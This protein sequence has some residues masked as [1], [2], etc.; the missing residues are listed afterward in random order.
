M[1]NEDKG[2]ATLINPQPMF[3]ILAK[4]NAKE[5]SGDYV[6][7]M[8]IGDTPGFR[9]VQIEELLKKF[10]TTPHRY[11]PSR[12]ES[13]LINVLFKKE[14][15]EIDSRYNGISIAPANFLIM[16]SLAS[17]TSPGD[18]VLIPDPGFPT[19]ELVCK[20]LKLKIQRYSSLPT[21]GELRIS[22]L[23]FFS[24][25]KPKVIIINNP[26]N[27]IG[28]AYD[29]KSI[30]SFLNS[31]ANSEV[32]VIIDETYVNLVY[33]DVDAYIP[34]ID[35][36]RIRTF[37]KEYCAPGLRIG[38]CLASNIISQKISDFISLT[39]SCTP[40]FIQLAVAEYL[41][42][43]E[44][45][46]FNKEIKKEMIRRFKMLKEIMPTNSLLTNPNAGFYA[47]IKTGNAEKAFDFFLENN[48]ST[49]PGTRF[50]DTTKGA[51]RISIAGNSNNIEKDFILLKNAYMAWQNE[52]C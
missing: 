42:S 6:A 17:I 46:N 15:P 2:W 4:A 23:E 47:L 37:S 7:R 21:D 25:D 29:G 40:K 35:A 24:E 39:I 52:N 19:Y 38:Y 44:S 48:V 11:S 5:I 18:V 12:G 41:E 43:S 45:T 13:A 10:S 31:I 8:E 22:N 32:K 20:F 49:C 34:D 14:W 28:L 27:P 36:I 30:S 9:N 26:S 1:T 3:D 50:G 33:D 51:L 16:A